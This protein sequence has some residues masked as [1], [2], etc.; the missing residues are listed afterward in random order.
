MQTELKRIQQTTGVTF[1]FVTHDQEEAIS[2]GDR[3]AV[4]QE[5]T[6]AQIGTPQEVYE[7]PA[8]RFV[9]DFIGETSF[10]TAERTDAGFR[11]KGGAVLP[12]D[13]VSGAGG[14]GGAGGEVTIA[15]RPEHLVI[16]GEDAPLHGVVR[17]SV[18]VGSDMR[19]GA[20][21]AGGEQVV[22]RLPVGAAFPEPGERVGL[23]VLPGR[24]WAVAS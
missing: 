19:V 11:L 16:G 1:V 15:L 5:G 24:G 6:V 18:Y 2:L 10:L 13:R 17:E 12:A 23:D 14:T 21:L 20:E 8:N 3:L 9:A 7:R 4:F 22:V